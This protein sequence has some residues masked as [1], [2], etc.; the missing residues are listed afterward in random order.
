MAPMFLGIS[1]YSV[2]KFVTLN[3]LG[4]VVWSATVGL[5]GWFFGATV[6]R[7]LGRAARVEEVLLGTVVV[8]VVVWSWF[9]ARRKH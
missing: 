7:V 2:G 9:K 8:A 1:K 5:L 6:E 3:L 4:A